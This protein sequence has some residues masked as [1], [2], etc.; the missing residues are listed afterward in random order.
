MLRITLKPSLYLALALTGAHSAAALVL[1]PLAVPTWAKPVLLALIA[2]SLAR[3]LLR[4]ACL[5]TPGA[6][7]VIELGENDSANVR[8]RDGEWQQARILPTTY[9]SPVLSVINVRVPPRTRA[10]HMVIA[11][12]SLDAEAFRRLRVWLRWKYRQE[13]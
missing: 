10:R 9:V 1:L 7:V 13:E 4:H 6:L 11:A 5:R 2:A 3:A 12:D 8:N